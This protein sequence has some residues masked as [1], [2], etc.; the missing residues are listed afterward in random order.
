[1]GIS[2]FRDGQ[3]R[4]QAS[5]DGPRR[6]GTTCGNTVRWSDAFHLFYGPFRPSNANVGKKAEIGVNASYC[7][8][9][10]HPSIFFNAFSGFRV[11]SITKVV[12][13][14]G[15]AYH[16]GRDWPGN[17]RKV[18]AGCGVKNLQPKSWE[19]LAEGEGK[20]D[21]RGLEAPFK[22]LQKGKRR[23]VLG[24]SRIFIS[25][26]SG[27]GGFGVVQRKEVLGDRE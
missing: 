3:A 27:R 21:R 20:G 25:G 11:P 9:F 18:R 24:L 8:L 10:S 12:N 22:V 7:I 14:R 4:Q 5:P 23:R 15:F 26:F 1:M 16:L 6:R 2:R 19:F 17:G 13:F